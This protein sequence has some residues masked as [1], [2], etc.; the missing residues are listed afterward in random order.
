MIRPCWTP[1]P[2]FSS[3]GWGALRVSGLWSW[4]AFGAATGLL[5]IAS[6]VVGASRGHRKRARGAS[7]TMN[8]DVGRAEPTRISPVNATR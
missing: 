8:I 4:M 6:V 5:S 2:E 7:R 3:T 1:T